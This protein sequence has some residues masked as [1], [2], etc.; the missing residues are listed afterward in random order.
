MWQTTMCCIFY[1]IQNILKKFKSGKL[2]YYA[3][4]ILRNYKIKKNHKFSLIIKFKKKV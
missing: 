3:Y 4:L 1:F 2:T